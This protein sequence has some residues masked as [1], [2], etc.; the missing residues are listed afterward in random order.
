MQDAV[1][2]VYST[3]SSNAELMALLGGEDAEKGWYRIYDSPNAPNAKEFPRL[4]L[5]EAVND[6]AFGGDDKPLYSDVNIRIGFWDDTNERIHS[7]CKQIKKVLKDSF[8]CSVR[9]ESTL[10]E[11][12]TETYHKPLNVYLLLEQGE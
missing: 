1:N 9:I 7:V 2:L 10:F 4:T 3:L 5:F 11:S 12:D 6:D 8:Q